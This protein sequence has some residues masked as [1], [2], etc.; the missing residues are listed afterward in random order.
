[1]TDKAELSLVIL[2]EEEIRK[3]AK[4][5]HAVFTATEEERKADGGKAIAA[6]LAACRVALYHPSLVD[7]SSPIV[8]LTSTAALKRTK[9]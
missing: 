6:A 3:A 7:D 5:L 2:Y 8:M 4:L 1:M 9:K